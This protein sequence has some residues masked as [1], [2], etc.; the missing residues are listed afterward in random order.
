MFL[1]ELLDSTKYRTHLCFA[2]SLGYMLRED[3]L[4]TKKKT[5]VRQLSDAVKLAVDATQGITDIVESM[6][7]LVRGL[8][9]SAN[10]SKVW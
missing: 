9:Y 10:R 7:G 6:T 1:L 2:V 3:F 4:V 8:V 5:L